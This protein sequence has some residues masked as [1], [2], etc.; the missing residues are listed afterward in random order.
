MLVLV[1]VN[2]MAMVLT[3]FKHGRKRRREVGAIELEL[4]EGSNDM[5]V[6]K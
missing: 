1:V 3:L 6:C 4:E 5:A 2:F